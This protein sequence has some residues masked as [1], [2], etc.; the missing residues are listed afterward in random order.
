MKA[1]TGD[2]KEIRRCAYIWRVVLGI[3]TVCVCLTWHSLRNRVS[4]DILSFKN[5]VDVGGSAVLSGAPISAG[6]ALPLSRAVV[7]DVKVVR[8]GGVNAIKAKFLRQNRDLARECSCSKQKAL[9]PPASGLSGIEV[10]FERMSELPSEAGLLL[11]FFFLTS[12]LLLG[13]TSSTSTS[14]RG[15]P[16]APAGADPP[17]TWFKRV[18]IV[19]AGHCLI[20]GLLRNVL[21]RWCLKH[22]YTYMICHGQAVLAGIIE[23][24]LGTSEGEYSCV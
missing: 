18:A 2:N 4:F 20:S 11:F 16:T 21:F 23:C 10:D 12:T 17:R 8:S 14:A 3:G 22:L 5:G 7:V 13:T 6:I 9:S 15:A 19:G 24:R 1:I